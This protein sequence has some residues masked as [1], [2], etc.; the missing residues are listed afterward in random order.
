MAACGREREG[1]GGRRREG[2]GKKQRARER[3]VCAEWRVFVCACVSQ[4]HRHRP[5]TKK[6]THIQKQT[7]T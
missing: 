4:R 5:I 7:Q 1:E 6:Q 3:G 2:E